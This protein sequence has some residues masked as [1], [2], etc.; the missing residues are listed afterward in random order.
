MS[1]I[2][3]YTTDWC[4]SCNA[5]KRFLESKSLD[6]EEVNI[7][8]NRIPRDKLME[9]TGRLAVP[10]VVIDGKVIGGLDNLQQVL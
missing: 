6:Y 2:I 7:E 8:T 10:T 5:V 4:S 9:L 3:V 1:K